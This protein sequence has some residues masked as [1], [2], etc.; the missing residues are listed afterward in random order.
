MEVPVVGKIYK[1]GKTKKGQ[2]Y[3]N[4][5]IPRSDGQSDS[6]TLFTDREYKVGQEI[7]TKVNAFV[8]MGTE[9]H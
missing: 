5:L 9:V 7:K 6:F 8:Q 4:L 3:Y 1:A 2:N